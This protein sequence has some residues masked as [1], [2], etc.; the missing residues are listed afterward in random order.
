MYADLRI[1]AIIDTHALVAHF[2]FWPQ[3]KELLTTDLL[4][5]YA[6]YAEEMAC[7]R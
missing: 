6:A 1:A 4:G 5:R 7:T 2:S 3:E